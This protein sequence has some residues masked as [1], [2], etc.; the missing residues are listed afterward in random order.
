M[1][2]FSEAGVPSNINEALNANPPIGPRQQPEKPQ[3]NFVV[4]LTTWEAGSTATADSRKNGGSSSSWPAAISSL[5]WSE[6]RPAVFFALDVVG[7]VHAFDLLEDDAGPVASEGCPHA[8]AGTMERSRS[9]TN[10]PA[11]VAEDASSSSLALP[12]LALSSETLATGRRPKV[13]LAFGGSVFAKTLAGRMF[14]QS[15]PPP[16]ASGVERSQAGVSDVSERERMKEWLGEVLW[17]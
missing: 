10:P 13:A 3:D 5:A 15:R 8:S 17:A 2:A 4:P 14:R 9:P 6:H 16:V 7:V 12:T 1:D 11:A